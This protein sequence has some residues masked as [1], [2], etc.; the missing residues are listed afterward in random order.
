MTEFVAK[1]DAYTAA[2]LAEEYPL[3]PSKLFGFTELVTKMDQPFPVVVNGT[4]DRSVIQVSLDD[5][6]DFISWIRL[7]GTINNSQDED[8]NWG[9]KTSKRL[10]A[11][12]RWVIAHDVTLGENLI[13][14]LVSGL[15]VILYN[16]PGYD[17]VFIDEDIDIDADHEAI[18]RT[19]LGETAYEKHRF[20]WNIYVVELNF[21]FNKCVGTDIRLLESGDFR[22][23]E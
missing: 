18:Y 23:L 9:L 21:E 20:D 2:F 7:P 17:F 22:I 12:L 5:R 13:N 6:Y 19:E 15:P 4:G 14:D 11:G 10:Q 1:I 3:I 16:I 8:D